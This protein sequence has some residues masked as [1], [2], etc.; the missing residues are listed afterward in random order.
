MT[1]PTDICFAG[2]SGLVGHELLLIL[3]VLDEVKSLKV[4][5]R[6]PLGKIP[7]HVD[8]IILNFTTLD[9]HA[10]LLKADV[11]VCCLGTTI[12]KAKSREAFRE[13]DY[14]LVMNFARLAEK[15]QAKKFL[16]ISAMGADPQSNIFYNRVKGEMERDLR[17]LKIPQ[18]EIFRPS[19]I[20]GER[21]EQR[22]AEIWAQ[23]M[24]P[25]FNRILVGPLQKY[26]A[27]KATDIAKAMAIAILN[28]QPGIHVYE[29][30]Q[31]QFIA[32]QK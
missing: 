27:I 22:T 26:R 13:V 19:L 3:S 2:A 20:L 1:Y 30:D 15:C 23:R 9:A 14:E 18:I 12:K 10:D 4:V 29:S 25:Y 32:N 24:S 21:K 28:F 6:S 8:N 7:P 31:I 5:S 16:V 17:L 11:F